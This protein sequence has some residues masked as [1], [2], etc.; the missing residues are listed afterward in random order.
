MKAKLGLWNRGVLVHP[1]R[2]A[3][4]S[5]G[6]A[7]LTLVGLV[8]CRLALAQTNTAGDQTA[9]AA[10]TPA[11]VQPG[12]L[13]PLIQ[14]QDVPLTTAIEN[15]ARQASLNYILDPKVN[16]G[17]PD[18]KGVVRSQPNISIR[19]ENL[20]AEQALAAL[21]NNYSLQLLEDP[22]TKIAR[23]T[24]KDPLAPDPL[25]TKIFQL[26]F[27]NPSNILA[28]VNSTIDP[29]RSKVVADIRTSQLVVVATEKELAGVDEL[30][31]RLDTMTKQVLIEARLMETSKNPISKKG[32]DWSGTLDAQNISFG[33]G[34]T[35]G[36][37]RTTLPGTPVTTTTTLPG[38]RTTTS[39][40]APRSTS[41]TVLDTVLGD[42]GVSLN[43]LSGFSPQTAF[44]NADGV[45]AVL[46]FLNKDADAQVLATPRAVTL[47]NETAVLSV[48]RALPIFKNTAG[49]QGS[50]GGSEVTYTNLGTILTVTPRISANDYINL[51]VIPEVSSV[52]GTTRKTVAGTI[53]EADIYD[54]RTIKTEVMIPSGNTLVLGGLMSDDRTKGYIKVPL[55]G[56]IPVLG[57]AFRHETKTQL[58]K[59][60]I[61]FIT[62]TIVKPEDFQPTESNFLKTTP[63][64]VPDEKETA[65][66]SGKPYDWSKSKAAPKEEATSNESAV[67]PKKPAVPAPK[68]PYQP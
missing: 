52:G 60:L 68:N 21:L 10:T 50:P 49:T 46:S 40:T 12:E 27:T 63:A 22:K 28:A 44:L 6:R 13:I 31:A 2:G 4:Y 17:Q 59:N 7:T 1:R 16:F 65:W 53:S 26:K 24:N 55:L 58:K 42:G 56:D 43:T 45:H 32:I 47:D 57:L 11:P 25:A 15:L 37:T 38:G 51:K 62:P 67:T 64:K 8:A 20:T 18:E 66:D 33:N 14:L 19:W 39:T 36:N 48:T 5:T 61:I 3:W 41:Q 54:I 30:I 23:V 9:S 29:K 34:I 35:T